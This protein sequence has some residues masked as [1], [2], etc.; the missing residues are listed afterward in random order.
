MYN[1]LVAGTLGSWDESPSTL[2]RSRVGEY[3]DDA[4]R[5]TGRSSGW[6]TFVTNAS[7]DVIVDRYQFLED[8]TLRH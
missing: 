7:G 8:C 5:P 6:L 2:D 1:L 4:R 3:T